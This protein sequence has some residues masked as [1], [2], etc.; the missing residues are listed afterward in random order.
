MNTLKRVISPALIILLAAAIMIFGLTLLDDT[1]WADSFRGEPSAHSVDR[2][3][4]SE[5]SESLVNGIIRSVDAFLKVVLFMGIPAF[6]TLRVLRIINRKPK[7]RSGL[8]N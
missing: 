8:T 5:G 2:A 1:E 3:V 7:E 6:L 4:V